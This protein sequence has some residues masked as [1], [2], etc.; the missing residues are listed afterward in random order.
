MNKKRVSEVYRF[1][2]VA[3]MK[4][5]NDDERIALIRLL[6]TMKPVFVELKDAVDDALEKA[7]A[8]MEDESHIVD[9][10]NRAVEDLS[11]QESDIETNIMQADTFNRL[12]IS[13]DWNFAQIDELEEV[14]VTK[15]NK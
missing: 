6:R 11:K 9:F 5:M 1:L 15:D 12:C 8:E 7:K 2:S 3:S 10:V 4:K 14:L 13:N